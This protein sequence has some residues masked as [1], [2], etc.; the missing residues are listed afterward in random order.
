MDSTAQHTT[1]TATIASELQLYDLIGRDYAT[2]RRAD[3]RIATALGAA[4]GDAVSVLN[5]G[6]GAGSYEP[7]DRQVVALDPSPVM[8]AQRPPRSAPVVRGRAENLPFPDGAFDAVLGVLTLHHWSDGLEGL[9]ECARVARERVV[10]LTC[11]P[12]ATGFWLTEHYLPEF[13]TLDREEYF[14]PVDAFM[15]AF[16]LRASV[17]VV[18]VPIPRDCIDGFLGAFWARPSAYLDARVRAGISSFAYR[19]AEAGLSRLRSDLADGTWN[20]RFGHLLASD[21]LDI[22]YRLVIARLPVCRDS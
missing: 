6:A 15:T 4:L 13:S 1:R 14:P 2:Q 3:P 22:G 5:V 16:G 21:A 10:L 9:R 12:A 7:P 19:D 17:S 11:D 8:I 20:A 18:P